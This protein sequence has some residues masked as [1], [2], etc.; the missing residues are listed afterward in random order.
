MCYPA[1]QRA[2]GSALT[3][4]DRAFVLRA[5]VHRFTRQHRP[6]WAHSN[7]NYKPQFAD[8]NDWLANTEFA[9]RKN[10]RLDRRYKGCLSN[11]TW[12]DGKGCWGG[13]DPA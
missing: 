5:Y 8:D 4:E 1:N 2:N 3:N 13:Q 6:A 9:V 11:P 10:G 12:P 7:P